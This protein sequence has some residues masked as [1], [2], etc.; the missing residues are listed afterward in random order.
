MNELYSQAIAVMKELGEKARAKAL[1]A[2]SE[3]A[4][5]K[6]YIELIEK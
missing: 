2:F 1:K 4:F 3:K 5:V 6:Q